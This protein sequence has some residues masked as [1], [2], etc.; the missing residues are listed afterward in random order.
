M[1]AL[2]ELPKVSN[3][4]GIELTEKV[5]LGSSNQIIGILAMR[6]KEEDKTCFVIDRSKKQNCER[7]NKR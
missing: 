1:Y 7:R 5:K 4:R 3:P 6:N 2:P